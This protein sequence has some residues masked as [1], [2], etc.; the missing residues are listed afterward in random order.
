MGVGIPDIFEDMFLARWGLEALLLEV[1]CIQVLSGPR[2]I[3][4]IWLEGSCHPCSIVQA[5]DEHSQIMEKL[6]SLGLDGLRFTDS[7]FCRIKRR[8]YTIFEPFRLAI[9][10]QCHIAVKHRCSNWCNV[11]HSCS[12][13]PNVFVHPIL[14]NG[15]PISLFHR[16][17]HGFLGCL[18][19]KGPRGCW[20]PC[21]Q[22]MSL[23]RGSTR[24]MPAMGSS[25]LPPQLV[26]VI[27]SWHFPQMF[28]CSAKGLAWAFA[29]YGLQHRSQVGMV[30]SL[31]VWLINKLLL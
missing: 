12:F 13:S 11:M 21:N 25:G 20:K 17:P 1:I 27:S 5:F 6:S 29:Q 18:C 16:P 3:D 31:I 2:I 9:F 4:L 14:P 28:W 7:Y 24:G 15:S 8:Y 26:L 30:A 22:F 10:C 19:V 23:S